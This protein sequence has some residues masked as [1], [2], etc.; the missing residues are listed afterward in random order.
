MNVLIQFE[1]FIV[2]A[3]S[4]IYNFLVIYK[5]GESRQF[6]VKVPSESFRSTLLKFQD[7]PPISFERLKEELAGETQELHAQAHLN[8]AAPDI[9][10]YME[11]HY[12]PKARKGRPIV[13]LPPSEPI[14]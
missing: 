1:G 11:R 5:P 2:S 10:G 13:Q 14:Y 7:G 4:R 8:I 3:T 6:S 9:Q 12:P